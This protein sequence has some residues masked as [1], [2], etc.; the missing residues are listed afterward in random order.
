M[1]WSS[2]F[3]HEDSTNIKTKIRPKLLNTRQLEQQEDDDELHDYMPKKEIEKVKEKVKEK[4]KEKEINYQP[5]FTEEEV[6]P[7]YDKPLVNLNTVFDTLSVTYR[8][9]LNLVSGTAGDNTVAPV[10]S[11]ASPSSKPWA[12]DVVIVAILP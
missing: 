3:P 4:E 9:P 11:T 12:V 6:Y 2:P 5:P 10:I 1:N 8:I 7:A